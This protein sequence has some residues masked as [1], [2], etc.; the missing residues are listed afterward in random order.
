MVRSAPWLAKLA[1]TSATKSGLRGFVMAQG[2]QP[3]GIDRHG[4]VQRPVPAAVARRGGDRR[5]HIGVRARRP[6]GAAPS[7]AP[8]RR[9]S[10]WPACS[11]C[12]GCAAS[13]CAA[14]GT[15][16]SPPSVA[17][18]SSTSRPAR[19]PPF[20]S[21]AGTPSATQRRG[22][23]AHR[24]LVGDR[25]AAQR[26]RLRQ[27]G[28]DQRGQRQQAPPEQPQRRARP[29]AR[30][31]PLATMTGSTTSG[32]P[33]AIAAS[34]SQTAAIVAAVAEHAG[35]DHVGADVVQHAR[36]FAPRRT[37]AAPACTPARRGVL[38]GQRGDRGHGV[39][40]ERRDRLDVG[41]DARAAA[42]IG[43][44]D[45][46]HPAAHQAAS[47]GRAARPRRC[48]RTDSS[49]SRA[50]APRPRLPPSPAPAARCRWAD[51]QAAGAGQRR[52]GRG[53]RRAA[54]RASAAA[55]APEK[56][57]FFS[58]C[59]SGSNTRHHL[60]GRPRRCSTSTASTCSAAS[61]PSPVVA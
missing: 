45:H 55:S 35:L 14:R 8:A 34:T 4:M 39:A 40:A 5:L 56:R 48:A 58:R 46:Q 27:V 41:L 7:P 1:V 19:C 53:D 42:G 52:L 51:Q 17:S 25:H 21:T 22:G 13:R 60:A 20:S 54:R 15:P 61:S 29:A 47:V 43:S 33:R 37:P 24:G 10:R 2:R 44:G 49:T 16:P 28:G 12:R 18:R 31:P 3:G 6:R 23:A 50:P 9:R 32:T 57:T 38:R 11:R 59:G 26:L 36:P 30:A